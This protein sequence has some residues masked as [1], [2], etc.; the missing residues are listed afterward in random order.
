MHCSV[1][2]VELTTNT[3][4]HSLDRTSVQTEHDILEESMHSPV[5][6][7]ATNSRHIEVVPM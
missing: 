5:F 1:E 7:L 3:I 6:L 2:L 4:S